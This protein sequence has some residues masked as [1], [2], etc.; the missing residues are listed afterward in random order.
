MLVCHC[1]NVTDRAIRHAVRQG[2]ESRGE[3]MRACRAGT[4]CGGCQRAIE[5]VIDDELSQ[6]TGAGLVTLRVAS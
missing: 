5:G 6:Q 3:V 2:A 1:K 4:G